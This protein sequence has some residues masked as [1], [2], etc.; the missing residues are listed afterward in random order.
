M[1]PIRYFAYGSNLSRDQMARRCPTAELVGPAVLP[2][3]R[4]AFTHLSERWGG[5]V[6]DVVADPDHDTWG[7]LY[8]L[9]PDDLASLD[10]Y[11]GHPDRYDRH[12]TRVQGPDGPVD[13][14]WV[15]T[16]RDKLDHVPPTPVYL[17]VMVEAAEA[18]DFPTAHRELLERVTTA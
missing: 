17:A 9:R 15:Y 8:E 3:H 5:G 14:V 13:D 11:E 12:R 16:V 6:A 18:F 1:A 7:L 2:G 10:V 4:I